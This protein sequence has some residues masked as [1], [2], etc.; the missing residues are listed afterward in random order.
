MGFHP[1]DQR[2]GP[3]GKREPLSSSSGDRNENKLSDHDAACSMTGVEARITPV[4]LSW[5]P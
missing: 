2:A 4:E 1:V 5:N 3:A